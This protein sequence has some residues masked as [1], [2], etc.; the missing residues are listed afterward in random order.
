MGLR[1][2]VVLVGLLLACPAATASQPAGSASAADALLGEWTAN[3]SKSQ[4]DANHRFAGAMLR[5]EVDGEALLLIV[6]GVNASGNE[7]SSTTNYYPDGK[8][9][10]VEQVPGTVSIAEW[11]GPRTLDIKGKTGG[12]LVGHA[13]YEASVDGQM[14][15]ATIWGTDALGRPFEQVI[16]FDRD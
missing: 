9:Y 4:R 7:E 13:T 6:T 1:K 12:E 8:E 10:P 5:F 15:T 14:L 2:G 11:V 3:L 16:V